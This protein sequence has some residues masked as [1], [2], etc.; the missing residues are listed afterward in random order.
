M[1]K[2][3]GLCR[4][5]SGQPNYLKRHVNH[6]ILLVP[7]KDDEGANLLKTDTNRGGNA[8]H[9]TTVDAVGESDVIENNTSGD[10]N[11]VSD[12]EVKNNTSS[13]E[14]RVQIDDEAELTKKD[15]T[16][17]GLHTIEE[18]IMTNQDSVDHATVDEE[19]TVAEEEF[20]GVQI[21]VEVDKDKEGGGDIP[22][23]D[24]KEA[25]KLGIL[26]TKQ[27]CFGHER[28]GGIAKSACGNCAFHAGSER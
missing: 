20:E 10:E 13:D 18:I 1:N 28:G 17:E 27:K 5:K 16:T 15:G 8:I 6:L 24:V 23:P 4:Y 9:A 7:V 21:I 2:Q 3:D 11:P 22:I 19:I 25:G 12:D 14:N 26:M